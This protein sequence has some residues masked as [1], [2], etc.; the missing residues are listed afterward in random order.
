ML[1]K[2][3]FALTNT[4]VNYDKVWH[5][6]KK[7]IA[8][9]G[10]NNDSVLHYL[11]SCYTFEA[12]NNAPKLKNKCD[13]LYAEILRLK[14]EY[15]ES[16][17]YI[18]RCMPYFAKNKGSKEFAE[19]QYILGFCYSEQSNFEEASKH[20]DIALHI[21]DSLDMKLEYFKTMNSIGSNMYY[22]GK[23]D[24]AKKI[25]KE[26]YNFAINQNDTSFMALS[27]NNLAVIYSSQDTALNYTALYY[28]NKSLKIS[29]KLKE[30]LSI[31]NTLMNI[32]TIYS[33]RGQYEKAFEVLHQANNVNK[34]AND[35]IQS[36]YIYF[37][38]AIVHTNLKNI[39]SSLYYY[40]LCEKLSIQKNHIA[41]LSDIY[42]NKSE[43]YEKQGDFKN[44]FKN[45]KEAHFWKDSIWE[46]NLLQVSSD[47]GLKYDNQ[48]KINELNLKQALIDKQESKL[49]ENKT[50]NIG[51][52]IIA[53]MFL[54]MLILIFIY[55][56]KLSKINLRLKETNLLI[57]EKNKNL[58]DTINTRD[59]LISIIAH[60]I[61]N[62]L[63]TMAGFADLIASG[64]TKEL[65]QI[66]E[67]AD[68]IL[69][70]SNNLFELLENLL[71]WAKAQKDA[72]KTNP[73]N[74]NIHELIEGNISLLK[75]TASS[76]NIK[77]I[78]DCD[79]KTQVFA[80]KP[81]VNTIFRNIISNSLKFTNTEGSIRI[82][83]GQ[84]ENFIFVKIED[85]GI[86][87]KKEDIV[88][89][90]D[91]GAD[92]NTIG[93]KENK[94][95]GLGLLLCDEFVKLN[96]G[97]IS[98]TSEIGLGTSFYINLPKSI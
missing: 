20:L 19:C 86:G 28:Y 17:V 37:N 31:S 27:L 53:S 72:I 95:F 12:F 97:F 85:N 11:D 41:L 57:N 48:Q 96:K 66:Q 38:L 26:I 22:L 93:K 60:D 1:P 79:I 4:S 42:I 25:Y 59:R 44:A 91:S 29:E 30:F 24:L 65:T 77:I 64:E 73:K 6:Y 54:I 98:V 7:A 33:D 51:I 3:N 16:S 9:K 92:R 10:V 71:K 89:L 47:I 62:P 63:S 8:F 14:S 74:L 69:S 84:K 13:L 50:R 83:C 70:S 36:I 45:S 78:N 68:H 88:K 81:T 43:V 76:K 58:N 87:I 35:S 21:Y 80:D 5:I 2:K 18:H 34:K 82:S 67:Y 49:A 90:F 52:V 39:D 46:Q 56:R 55:S 61:K 94:G 75:H 23:S 15:T 40:N 32:S